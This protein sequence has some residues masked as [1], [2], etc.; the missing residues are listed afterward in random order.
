VGQLL[1]RFLT[2]PDPGLPALGDQPR[3]A[4]VI[5]FAGDYYV[6]ESSPA[7]AQRLFDCVYA[8]QDFHNE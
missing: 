4:F 6:V 5:A 7:R 1:S 8:V 3:H 2:D